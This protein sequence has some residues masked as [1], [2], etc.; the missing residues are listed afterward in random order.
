M[1]ATPKA[2][3]CIK[4]IGKIENMIFI[5]SLKR[6]PLTDEIIKRWK[7]EFF[8]EEKEVF[9]GLSYQVNYCQTIINFR[10]L[11]FTHIDYFG[12]A[13]FK[14]YRG[15]PIFNELSTFVDKHFIVDKNILWDV[16]TTFDEITS[17]DLKAEFWNLIT[18]VESIEEYY[19]VIK[20]KFREVFSLIPDKSYYEYTN[21]IKND[22][23]M[24]YFWSLVKYEIVSEGEVDSL[25]YGIAK[26]VDDLDFVCHRIF[27]MYKSFLPD[28][29]QTTERVGIPIE[30]DTPEAKDIFQKAIDAGFLNT[31]YS[32]NGNDNQKALFAGLASD[33]L[34]ITTPQWRG[35]KTV[36]L[37]SWKPFEQLWNVKG[38]ADKWKKIQS[39][40]TEVKDAE[41]IKSIF[42]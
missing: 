41:K 22:S 21:L 26:V 6:K 33:K 39:Y 35:K 4:M 18:D 24:A 40:S 29:E 38:L 28:N 1:K 34:G 5:C 36:E 8:E 42:I 2:D 10:L 32:F 19:Q 25:L 20:M 37:K 7:D 23:F 12:N 16:L 17:D 9:N 31:D 11:P 13:S 30:L 27:E 15:T 3:E 14:K